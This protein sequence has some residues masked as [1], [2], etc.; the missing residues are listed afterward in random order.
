MVLAETEAFCALKMLWLLWHV[1]SHKHRA[2]A[3]SYS[4]RY[5]LSCP[6]SSHNFI[7]LLFFGLCPGEGGKN[8]HC[9]CR[10]SCLRGKGDSPYRHGHYPH[11][12]YISFHSSNDLVSQCNICI[13]QIS[14]IDYIRILIV[15]ITAERFLQIFQILTCFALI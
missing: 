10:W 3:W 14:K 1:L 5:S 8:I 11:F 15:S 7:S 6:A 12:P 9:N 4:S 13:T 2:A